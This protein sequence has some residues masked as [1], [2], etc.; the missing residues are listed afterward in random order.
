MKFRS[1]LLKLAREDGEHPRCW[2]AALIAQGKRILG[3]S[4]N[5]ASMHAE[6]N[7]IRAAEG[8]GHS[9][10][11]TTL[12]T[13]MVRARSGKVGNGSPCPECME[14]IKAARISKVVVYL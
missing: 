2:H 13:L 8:A 14:A 11:N 6:T 7:A 10:R 1:H 9:L 4:T 12:Y 5:Y 3:E